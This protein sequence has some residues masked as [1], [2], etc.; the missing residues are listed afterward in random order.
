MLFIEAAKGVPFMM[1]EIM[2]RKGKNISLGGVIP[3]VSLVGLAR[4][5]GLNFYA[6]W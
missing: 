6:I 1:E 2:P 4:M 3:C 5:P